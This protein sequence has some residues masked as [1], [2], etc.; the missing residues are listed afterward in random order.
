MSRK[1]TIAL[2]ASVAILSAG[3]MAQARQAAPATPHYSVDTKMADIFADPA[4]RAVLSEFFR[5]RGEAAG[6]PE[7]PPEEQAA[8][9]ELIKGL[10]P[11]ELAGFPQ[12]NLDEEA[13][14]AL[15]EALAKVPAPAAGPAGSMPGASATGTAP[16]AH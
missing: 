6:Q 13:L 11:R 14:K 9:A 2:M 8:T 16:G 1:L 5:K 3:G 4:A 10:S 15:G 7:A 12:A